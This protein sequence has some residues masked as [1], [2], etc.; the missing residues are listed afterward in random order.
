MRTTYFAILA[1]SLSV[2]ACGEEAPPPKT[3]ETT[4]VSATPAPV[5]P[6][7]VVETAPPPAPKPTLAELIQKNSGLFME[8]MMARDA[9]K[10]ASTYTE[11]AVI[12][13]A[14]MPDM[15]GREALTAMWTKQFEAITDTKGGASRVF[16]KGDVMISEWHMT[17]KHTGEFYGVKATN[18]EVGYSGVS[19]TWFNEEGQ[20]KEEHM[21][22]DMPTVMAQIGAPGSPKKFRAPPTIPSKPE[23]FASTGAEGETKNVDMIKATYAAVE[24]KSINDFTANM[25]DSF[26]W[27][28]LSM[29]APTKGKAEGKKMMEGFMKAFPDAKLEGKNVWGFGNFIVAEAVMTGTQKGDLPGIKATKKPVTL[30]SVDIFEV[31]D[32]KLVS[33]VSY[34]NGLQMAMQL[35]LVKDPAAK[36]AAAPAKP[37]ATPAKK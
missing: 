36:P 16:L 25:V 14:G 29:P 23:M 33:G 4:A 5:A 22:F 37:A 2:F 19:V 6:P 34:A 13:V 10:V 17:G 1:A 30:H 31:K 18:K 24:K 8:G 3:P 9:K 11:N 32:G 20:R 28:D 35:G 7:P 12:K 15:A 27:N 21:Y 26:E